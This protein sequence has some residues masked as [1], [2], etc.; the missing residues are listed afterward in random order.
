MSIN[1]ITTGFSSQREERVA[2]SS[3]VL[4]CLHCLRRNLSVLIML[5]LLLLS[6]VVSSNT[7]SLEQDRIRFSQA[8][9]ALEQGDQGVFSAIAE[10][11]KSYILYPYLLYFDLR[12]R[13]D[14]ASDHEIQAFIDDYQETPLSSQL[15]V[16]W[17]HQLG[18]SK[19]W[20]KYL[21]LYKGERN[22]KLTCYKLQG[23]L[24]QSRS[25]K[26]RHKILGE[27]EKLWMVGYDQSSACDPVLSRLESTRRITV[28][29]IW[30]RIELAMENGNVALAK[31]LS[32][33]FNKR[34]RSLVDVW[35][36]VYAQPEKG[37]KLRRLK[38]DTR[39][40]RV[41]VLYGV[42]SIARND[43]TRAH[44]LWNDI[45]RRYSFD[46]QTR[47]EIRRYIALRAAYQ[48]NENALAW[49]KQL[50]PKWVDENVRVWRLHMALREHNWQEIVDGIQLLT[51]SEQ[52]NYKWRYWLARGKE[53][54]GD[55]EEAHYLYEE[56]SQSTNYYG[57]LAADRIDS[58]YRFDVQPIER[59]SVQITDLENS[60][61]IQRTRELYLLDRITDARREWNV[62]IRSFDE[63]KVEQAALL[64]HE[65]QWH[66]NAILT[67][68]KTRH[69]TDLGLR[70]PTPYRDLV[71]LNA[72]TY[73]LDPSLIYGVARRESAFKIDARSGAG[74][75]GLMQL[76][77]STARYQ[78]RLLG[79]SR[80]SNADL[81]TSDKNIFLGSAYL[82]NMLRRFDGNQ[83]LA[84]AA[85]NAGPNRVDRWIPEFGVSA[86]IWVD[87][88]PI[89]ETRDYVRAVMAYSIIF[90][91]KLDGE[92]K[93]LKT[94]MTTVGQVSEAKQKI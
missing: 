90:N 77:P 56:L 88:M 2:S 38:R 47:G 48:F 53:Q 41:I 19:N 85:Y 82:N 54:L 58:E 40:N 20:D 30:Q 13:L 7:T 36:R 23:K 18:E 69:R 44:S 15:R 21:D 75:L 68:A 39:Q 16:K 66:D 42:K 60:P 31:R 9:A 55:L 79:V 32:Q 51:L 49:L 61:A 10:Q 73:D 6:T 92:V 43:A 72:E 93:T 83:V 25:G 17:L 52:Q 50:E 94:R 24:S 14:S 26:S 8:I 87:T 57:F 12:K 89:R 27:A 64:A 28:K 46:Q 29:K 86:D 4:V 71:F 78:S 3:S 45:G 65:W 22:T 70:F 11:S 74:A 33:R 34:D 76:M 1:E 84:T 5:P 62:A 59:D 35:A 80:P 63:S 67:V 81:L 91:W 37:L